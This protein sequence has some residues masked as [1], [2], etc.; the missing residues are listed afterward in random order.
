MNCNTI[1]LRK[2]LHCCALA[3]PWAWN[4]LDIGL[5]APTG[6]ASGFRGP[7]GCL[8]AP[9]GQGHSHT[10]MAQTTTILPYLEQLFLK[11]LGLYTP[12]F[13][14]LSIHTPIKDLNSSTTR[15]LANA[16]E[17]FGASLGGGPKHAPRRPCGT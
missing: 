10:E 13:I 16:F 7:G 5:N 14:I 11:K 4:L 3:V 17:F 8:V 15:L 12:I 2:W 1:V 6:C 9:A